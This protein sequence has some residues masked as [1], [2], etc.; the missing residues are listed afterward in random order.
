MNT[1]C[2]SLVR[3]WLYFRGT[4]ERGS[5]IVCFQHACLSLPPSSLG[6]FDHGIV[7]MV[8]PQRAPGRLLP[9][10]V[11]DSVAPGHRGEAEALHGCHAVPD[12]PPDTIC[13]PKEWLQNTCTCHGPASACARQGA[14]ELLQ[15]LGRGSGCAADSCALSYREIRKQQ[16]LKQ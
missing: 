11:T 8:P 16:L 13:T 12:R 6:T 9:T 7:G 3:H 15:L 14:E 10:Q 1:P 5:R 2:P 4:S